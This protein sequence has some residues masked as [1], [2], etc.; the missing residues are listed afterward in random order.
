MKEEV[1]LLSKTI[2]AAV[3]VFIVN[4]VGVTWTQEAP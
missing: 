1:D 4:R 3:S 2:A